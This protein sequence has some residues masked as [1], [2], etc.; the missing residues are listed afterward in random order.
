MLELLAEF[1]QNPPNSMFYFAPSIKT[2][3]TTFFN[4]SIYDLIGKVK[5]PNFLSDLA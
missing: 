5:S 2:Y 1:D 3:C 4:C